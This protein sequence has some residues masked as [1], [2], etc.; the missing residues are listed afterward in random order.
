[1]FSVDLAADGAGASWTRD[2]IRGTDCAGYASSLD[3]PATR[4]SFFKGLGAISREH[5]TVSHLQP[6]GNQNTSGRNEIQIRRNEIHF[7]FLSL[8]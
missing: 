7:L 6:G 4:S 3:K 2:T 5:W 1:V 8:I